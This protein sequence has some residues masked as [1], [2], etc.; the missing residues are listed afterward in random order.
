MSTASGGKRLMAEPRISALIIARDEAHNLGDCI[1]SLRWTDEVVVVV[2]PASRDATEHVAHDLADQV[3][4]RAFDN[5]AAQR[6]AGLDIISGE[7]VFSVDADERS[8]PEQADEIR[9]L[10]RR[11][12]ADLAGVRVPIRSEILGRSFSYSGTQFDRPLRLFRA[13]A[14]R[15]VGDVHETVALGGRVE[16]LQ[17]PLTHRTLGD[18]G[19]FLK[20]IDRY[21]ALEASRLHQENR[22]HRLTDLTLRPLW[23]FAKLYIGKQGFR[24]GLEGFMFCVLS[25]VSVCVRHWRH[26]ELIHGSGEHNS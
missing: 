2:D 23:T 18:V 7:W 26:R 1:A 21:T 12:P 16:T 20:K 14:G 3:Q 8:S 17:T 15:W 22:P 19:T 4:V 5:F 25:G 11:A 10:V 24:D 13:D 6:N 9:S